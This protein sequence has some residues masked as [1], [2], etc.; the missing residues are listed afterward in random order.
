MIFDKSVGHLRAKYPFKADSAILIDN[1][2]EALAC[3]K[4][5]EKRQIKNNKNNKRAELY[6]LLICTRLMARAASLFPGGFSSAVCIG[7]STC[8]I[9]SLEKHATA[10]HPYMHSRLSEVHN[11]RDKISEK[12]HLEEVY[13]VASSKNI[14]DICTCK[15]LF[16]KNLGPESRW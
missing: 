1:G 2:K 11:L 8:I 15:D 5:Q 9:S 16:L 7:D 13:H 3:Q 12:T 10:F 4:S 6:G 14:T